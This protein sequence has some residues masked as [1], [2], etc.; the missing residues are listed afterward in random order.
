M[1]F[2]GPDS[3]LLRGLLQFSYQEFTLPTSARRLQGNLGRVVV[4]SRENECEVFK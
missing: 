1:F 4:Q 3:S 2:L